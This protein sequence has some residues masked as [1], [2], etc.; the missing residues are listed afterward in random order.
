MGQD[1][2]AVFPFLRDRDRKVLA[3]WRWKTLSKAGKEVMMKSMVQA[4]P[5]YC[6]RVFKLSVSLSEELQ[7]MMD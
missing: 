5:N 4:I 7:G 1:K 6:I 3:G 2:K